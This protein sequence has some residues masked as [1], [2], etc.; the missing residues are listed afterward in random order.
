MTAGLP[1]RNNITIF[2]LVALVLTVTGS[3]VSQDAQTPSV[4]IDPIVGPQTPSYD[5]QPIIDLVDLN[6]V[7]TPEQKQQ[8]LDAIDA[9][10][11][12]DALSVEQAMEMLLLADWPSLVSADRI[13]RVLAVILNVL[14]DVAA[15][16]LLDDPVAALA[17][18]LG[19]ELTPAGIL[20]TIGR[21]GATEAVLDQVKDLVVSGFPP[22]ILVR[23]TKAALR[24]GATEAE[25][26]ALLDAAALEADGDSWGNVAND[27]T[28][29]GA[30]KYQDQERN[31]NEN[32]GQSEDPELEVEKNQHG[33]KDG[34][35]KTPPGQ[36]KKN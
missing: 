29:Q 36:D 23:I 16:V 34:D 31:D 28:S 9:A 2:V 27:L 4:I 8:L 10:L 24:S 30:H 13:D 3:A 6:L 14:G 17:D 12:T 32:A 22:G 21:S 11:L 19:E 1:K 20:N 35:K 26:A 7:A 25:I 33:N 15:G 18:R 5:L